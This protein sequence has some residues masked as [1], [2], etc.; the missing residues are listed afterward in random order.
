[1]G[2]TPGEGGGAVVSERMKED[3]RRREGRGGG[4]VDAT[5]CLPTPVAERREA[6]API[7][8]MALVTETLRSQ[9]DRNENGS[10]RRKEGRKEERE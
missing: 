1:M 5:N 6:P 10:G 3:E 2:G 9:I 4:G 8:W 7:E